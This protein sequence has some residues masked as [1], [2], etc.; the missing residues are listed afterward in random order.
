MQGSSYM[1]TRRMYQDTCVIAKSSYDLI[2]M[3]YTTSLL[4]SIN[5]AVTKARPD[6]RGGIRLTDLLL[7]VSSSKEFAAIFKTV[8]CKQKYQKRESINKIEHVS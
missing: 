5:E 4:N 7:S 8:L 1:D 6:L 2:L 3:S